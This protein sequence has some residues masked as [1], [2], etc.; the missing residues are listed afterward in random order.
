MQ[1]RL[2]RKTFAAA[3]RAEAR[4]ANEP[5]EVALIAAFMRHGTVASL[6]RA[7]AKR[8]GGRTTEAD[9]IAGADLKRKS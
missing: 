9:R 8:L 4:V 7:I 6:A 2:K 3:R 1:K 5:D